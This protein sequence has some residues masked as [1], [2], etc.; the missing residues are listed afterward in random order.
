MKK[1]VVLGCTGM[2]GGCFAE[3]LA[4]RGVEV[5]GVAR[6]T[7]MGRHVVERPY[8]FAGCDILDRQSLERVLEREKPDLVVDMAAQ[9]FN[10]TSWDAEHYTYLVNVE[11][12]NNVLAAV[13]AKVPDA[14][15]LLACSSAEY[16]D[17]SPEDC[18]LREDR[19]LRPLTPYGVTK[20]ATECMGY[21]YFKNFGM[22][23]Y[24]PRMFIHVGTGHPP[25]T[26]I[27]NFARQIA[28]AT[29]GKGPSLVRTGRL[30]TAR[31]FIDVRD[32]VEG[33]LT[34]LEKGEPGRPVN[35]C[36][37]VAPTIREVLDELVELSGAEVKFET[38]PAL[39]R[40]SDEPLLLGDNSRLRALGWTRRHPLR[41]T[42]RG[43]LDDWL[44][45]CGGA[46]L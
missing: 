7:A 41:E 38:D 22:K 34:L 20:V 14:K 36:N 26:A 19:P 23:V 15:L 37:G 4:E 18:P 30:D 17:I 44:R 40:P 35:I 16:G 13:R 2:V 39:L 9:A 27:Q 29:L 31:D 5:V 43:V 42:L 3:K 10:G 32:G 8:R 45:R 33:M 11:G 46:G 6:Q 25:A 28:L 21:Q 24:L 12:T 1:A